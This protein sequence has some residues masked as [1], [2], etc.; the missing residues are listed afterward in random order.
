MKLMLLDGGTSDKDMPSD[1]DL[2][3]AFTLVDADKSGEAAARGGG[4]CSLRTPPTKIP[5]A[6]R[7]L[8][9]PSRSGLVDEREFEMLFQLA[10]KGEV[11]GISKKSM[12]GSSTQVRGAVGYF[13]AM[14]TAFCLF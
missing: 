2:T 9:E 10:A 14:W 12:F 6:R 5:R 11:A 1:K 8:S 7:F 4:D 3:A 13:L